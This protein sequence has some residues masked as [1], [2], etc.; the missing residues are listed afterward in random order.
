[1]N[2]KPKIAFPIAR[3]YQAQVYDEL[4]DILIICERW[5]DK[6]ENTYLGES[7][8]VNEGTGSNTDNGGEK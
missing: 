1:M 5:R 7:N 6:K 4:L 3:T 2:P 8:T